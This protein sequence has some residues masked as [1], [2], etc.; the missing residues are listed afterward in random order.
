MSEQE[1]NDLR[2]HINQMCLIMDKTPEQILGTLR[3]RNLISSELQYE[4]IALDCE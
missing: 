4:L 3:A 2:F 1:K